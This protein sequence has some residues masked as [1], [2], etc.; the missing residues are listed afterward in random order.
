VRDYYP[1]STW[2]T[3]LVGGSH[4]FL[5]NGARLLDARAMMHYVGTGSQYA[6]TARDASGAWL[7]GGR[8]YTFTL[9]AGIPPRPSGPSTSTTP[10]TLAAADRQPVPSI[11]SGSDGMRDEP[12]GDLIIAFGPAAPEGGDGN[13]IQTRPHKGWFPILRIYGPGTGLLGRPREP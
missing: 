10:D 11:Q 6:F 8:D 7:D 9:P 1:D 4:E 5:A 2:A 12:N 13:W 3:A